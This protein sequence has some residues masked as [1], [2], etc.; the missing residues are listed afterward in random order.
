MT[1]TQKTF[2]GE[3]ASGLEYENQ[4]LSGPEIG[5]ADRLTH[6]RYLVYAQSD[7]TGAWCYQITDSGRLAIGDANTSGD[8]DPSTDKG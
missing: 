3:V 2:L 7:E 6:C 4:H 8:R 5:M 1:P